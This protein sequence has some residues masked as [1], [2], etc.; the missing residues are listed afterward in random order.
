[1]ES[2]RGMGWVV[3][4]GVR[5]SRAPTWPCS[6]HPPLLGLSANADMGPKRTIL[7]VCEHRWE[8]SRTDSYQMEMVGG[9]QL[10]R[11]RPVR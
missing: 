9:R 3:G 4:E 8:G 7:L 2:V 11:E 6:V 5:R 10:K 1:M